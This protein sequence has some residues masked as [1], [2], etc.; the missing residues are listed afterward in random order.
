[1]GFF[2]YLKRYPL[3]FEDT[4]QSLLATLATDIGVDT[5]D[6][7]ETFKMSSSIHV[8]HSNSGSGVEVFT[9]KAFLSLAFR[10]ELP[11]LDRPVRWSCGCMGLFVQTDKA[12]FAQSVAAMRPLSI[13]SAAA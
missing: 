2:I 10:H 7:D 12:K 9:S 4:V 8:M 3:Y 13:P 6:I 1:M 5:H 11:S